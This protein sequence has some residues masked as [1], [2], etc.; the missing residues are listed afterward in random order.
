[1]GDFNINALNENHTLNNVLSS[2]DQA[3]TTST[4]IC[5]SLLDHVYI[6]KEFSS[7]LSM[8][9]VIEIYF[10]DHDAVKFRLV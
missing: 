10:S 9:N 3:V 2:Y 5:G 4:H 1:M 8:S 6:S 7:E